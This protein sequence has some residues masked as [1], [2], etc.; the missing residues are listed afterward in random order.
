M[1]MNQQLKY[2]YLACSSHGHLYDFSTVGSVNI[3]YYIITVL[4][5]LYTLHFVV[6]I[7]KYVIIV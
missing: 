4:Y 5:V 6:L 1:A 3:M 2:Y 7:T